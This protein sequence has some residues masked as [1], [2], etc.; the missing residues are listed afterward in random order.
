MP[1]WMLPAAALTAAAS[2][3]GQ[4]RANRTNIRE[5]ARNRAFQERMS[6]TEYQRGVA[7]MEAAGLN[8]ALMYQRAGGASTPGGAQARVDDAVS[9]AVSGAMQYARMREDLKMIRAQVKKGE[10]DARTAN[11]NAAWQE[12]RLAAYGIDYEDGSLR[13]TTD[14][15]RPTMYREIM[16]AIMEREARTGRETA[17]TRILEPGA[18]LADRLGELLPILMLTQGSGALRGAAR[19]FEGPLGYGRRS[20]MLDRNRSIGRR[21]R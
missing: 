10:A 19:M 2:F 1:A 4:E 15:A 16:A 5:A 3:A 7:D 8:P 18:D 6:S 12:A 14:G 21:R 9:P 17:T 13:F 11:A 20:G